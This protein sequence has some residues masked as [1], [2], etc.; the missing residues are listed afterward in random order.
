MI[1]ETQS[2]VFT[3]SN[4]HSVMYLLLGV[5]LMD[6]QGEK[7]R[8]ADVICQHRRDGKIIPIKI[9]LEDEDGEF[10]TYKVQAYK[11]LTQ[12]GKYVT[13]E[14]VSSVNHIWKYECKISVFGVE[15]RIRLHYNAFDN[16]WRVSPL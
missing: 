14:G 8:I 9:R 2:D 10:Q 13:P 15:K 1:T 3:K 12:Y 6:P 11:D 5:L 16:R 7:N 4:K